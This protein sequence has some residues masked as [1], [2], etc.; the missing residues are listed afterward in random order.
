MNLYEALGK[1]RIMASI[2]Y[3]QCVNSSLDDAK[4]NEAI[5]PL[6]DKRDEMIRAA[7][8]ADLSEVVGAVHAYR[9]EARAENKKIE[10]H[11]DKADE[12]ITHAEHIL[13]LLQSDM[14]AKG[15]HERSE[16]GYMVTLINGKV[17]VR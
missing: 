4:K 8:A 16:K 9:E 11:R 7:I 3:D 13:D 5:Q 2:V 14:A 1:I 15:E 12:A 6:R 17:R 10:W